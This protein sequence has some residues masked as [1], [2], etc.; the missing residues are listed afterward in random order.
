M[1]LPNAEVIVQVPQKNPFLALDRSKPIN[2][3]PTSFVAGGEGVQAYIKALRRGEST[4]IYEQ[5]QNQWDYNN[6]EMGP[7]L[8]YITTKKGQRISFPQLVRMSDKEF[9]KIKAAC[10]KTEFINW[11]IPQKLFDPESLVYIAH[12][13]KGTLGSHGRGG[14]EAGAAFV[15]DGQASSLEYISS[16]RNGPWHGQTVM[17]IDEDHFPGSKTPAYTLGYQRFQPEKPLE[18]TSVIIHD[19]SEQFMIALRKLP[20]Y[21]LLANPNYS[22]Y[23]FNE[24]EKK[25]Q[26]P[27][28]FTVW[29]KHPEESPIN[30]TG[31]SAGELNLIGLGPDQEEY[32]EP[33]RVEILPETVVKKHGFQEGRTDR[34]FVDGLSM[35]ASEYYALNWSFFGCG[36]GQ[37]GYQAQR[38]TD[39]D[40][41]RGNY[42][43]LMARVL[44]KCTSSEVFTSIFENSLNDKECAE[45]KN[46][47]GDEFINE[48][49][50]NPL[51]IT[52]MTEAWK[53]LSKSYKFD[54]RIFV[55]ASADSLSKAERK[56]IKAVKINSPI[57]VKALH[58][59]NIVEELEQ[60]VDLPQDP[61]STGE[62][63]KQ[64]RWYETFAERK[65]PMFRALK[66]IARNHGK[67]IFNPQGEI[68]INFDKN[69]PAWVN[70]F[71]SLPWNVETLCQNCA[72]YF[73]NKS[74]IK[75]VI[76][77]GEG[78]A[79][80]IQQ[81]VQENY[82]EPGFITIENFEQPINSTGEIRTVLTLG[83]KEMLDNRDYAAF[84]LDFKKL[85][86]SLT[87]DGQT[88]DL[89]KLAKTLSPEDL[90]EDALQGKSIELAKIKR[91]IANAKRQANAELD[92]VQNQLKEVKRQLGLVEEDAGL[93]SPTRIGIHPNPEIDGWRPPKDFQRKYMSL[94]SPNSALITSNGNYLSSPQP[95]QVPEIESFEDL[96]LYLKEKHDLLVQP[97]I[98]MLNGH[99]LPALIQDTLI[100]A[101][102]KTLSGE[103]AFEPIKVENHRSATRPGILMNKTIVAKTTTIPCPPNCRVVGF[104][105]PEKNI[106]NQIKINYSPDRGFY[107]FESQIE[108]TPGL[109]F[110]YEHDSDLKITG[111][112][113]PKERG[114]LAD[115]KYLNPK[116]SE[117]IQTVKIH[118]PPLTEK[119]KLDI[120]LT[121][122]LH[123]FRYDKDPRIDAQYKNLAPEERAAVIVNNARGNCGYCSE[124][125]TIL[126]RLLDLPSTVLSGYLGKHGRFFP[127]PQN[128]GLSGVF[129]NNEWVVIEP[130]RSY[131]SAGYKREVISKKF[132]EIIKQIPLGENIYPLIEQSEQEIGVDEMVAK[133]K[134]LG[135][136]LDSES[137]SLLTEI[138][139]IQE[140]D[141]QNERYF[142]SDEPPVPGAKPK[143]ISPQPLSASNLRQ[144]IA[145]NSKAQ[146]MG[147]TKLT[148]EPPFEFD[149]AG[150]QEFAFGSSFL[151]QASEAGMRITPNTTPEEIIEFLLSH[152]TISATVPGKSS[153]KIG[154]WLLKTARK[155]GLNLP[156]NTPSE[157]LFALVGDQAIKVIDAAYEKRIIKPLGMTAIGIA[158]V[159]AANN[160]VELFQLFNGLPQ[161]GF[162]KPTLEF[163]AQSAVDVVNN[164]DLGF[165]NSSTLKTIT[166]I[167]LTG[168]GSSALIY[169]IKQVILMKK[170]HNYIPGQGH[171]PGIPTNF[172]SSKPY[173]SKKKY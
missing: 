6:D 108:V 157:A 79:F 43:K 133:L 69:L 128:H 4:P 172:R 98:K 141:D 16:D 155:K 121:A 35:E 71:S 164:I 110:Y 70:S 53:N 168:G 83:H 61:T 93:I 18:Q 113:T 145:R 25:I 13:N 149:S 12:G 111:Q 58:K 144:L 78:K 49:S 88:I 17:A 137:L 118:Q 82:Y 1:I 85:F 36:N 166:S 29:A 67:I 102:N 142:E 72:D 31:F 75:L 55:T 8:T 86:D 89:E 97:D 10:Q 15:V 126:C 74:Q 19:P 134:K 63:N 138:L 122:W 84:H 135:V 162:V 112:P 150:T 159:I 7:P 60:A 26:K 154:K 100:C 5:A 161:T 62:K 95:H 33:P 52:A 173:D 68:V 153:T 11:I 146:A 125:F 148:E 81:V 140:I 94:F 9:E 45:G 24:V 131:L 34:I 42:N 41:V 51:A 156:E 116:W 30:S 20:D 124:G 152:S 40:Y 87:S 147:L 120:A 65:L 171:R 56:N 50:R 39:S 22:G 46:L 76:D 32:R 14:K 47:P 77:R 119:Q 38:S 115:P 54:D 163:L 80:Q 104:Y 28:L 129:I 109:E 160:I 167:I 66:D 107:N 48:I 169:K 90:F 59:F 158:A 170:L 105:H 136:V 21:F 114:Q 57:L 130:Q 106:A 132:A 99:L 117:L 143:K 103:F 44:G 92:A 127:G 23:R 91:E 3:I 2:V 73:G 123:A 96:H 139:K 101:Q 64:R 165:T 37:H 27:N 151:R